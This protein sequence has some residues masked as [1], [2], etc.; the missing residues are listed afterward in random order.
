MAGVNGFPKLD[1]EVVFVP[2]PK[3]DPVVCDVVVV[4]EAP[5]GD[6]IVLEEF[7]NPDVDVVEVP[8][9]L[10]VSEA[11]VDA[12][13]EVVL[14]E[15]PNGVPKAVA[16]PKPVLVAVFALLCCPKGPLLFV[17]VLVD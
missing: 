1:P 15:A 7:P 16:L 12:P 11:D 6:G 13:K 14:E 9:A 4:V 3:I 8:K 2:C 17:L 5:K 10:L